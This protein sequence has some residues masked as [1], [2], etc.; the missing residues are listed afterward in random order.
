[1]YMEQLKLE[2]S[3]F[4][5]RQNISVAAL[6]RQ[7]TSYWAWSGSSAPLKRCWGFKH[8]FEI[9]EAKHFKFLVLIDTEE[10]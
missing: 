5:Y 2:L 4:V 9:G 1:M 6:R 7:T 10:Y 3:N 8:I